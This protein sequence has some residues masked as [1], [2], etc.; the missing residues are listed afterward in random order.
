LAHLKRTRKASTPFSIVLIDAAM[1]EMDGFSLAERINA[2]SERAENMLLMLPFPDRQGVTHP[3]SGDDNKV[4]GGPTIVCVRK[5]V[6]QMELKAAIL[7]LLGQNPKAIP[8]AG[9]S[10]PLA[11]RFVNR[12]LRILMAEDNPFNQRVTLLMLTK[13]GHS[14]AVVVNGREAIAALESASF[15]LVLMDL[16][17]PEMDGFEATAAIRLA[18]AG[19]SRHVPIIALTAHAMKED[20]DRCLK[21]G[22][23]GYVSKPIQ[24]DKLRQAIED[25]IFQIREADDAEPLEGVTESPMDVAAALARIDGDR[26]FL[27]EMAAMFRDQ[28]PRFLEE[29]RAGI[30]SADMAQSAKAV[31]A[32]KNWLANFVALPAL[33][34]AQVLEATLQAGNL[35]AASELLA[36][37]RHQFEQFAPELNRLA[38][39]PESPITSS[40]LDKNCRQRPE[41]YICR[42]QS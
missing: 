16:Q 30:D 20:R 29:A 5:P 36:T 10:D 4:C 9:P 39:G 27:A 15:D 25:C 35:G 31:H 19:T 22:M 24:Q 7:K 12:S 3:I 41:T 6:Q 26:A 32:L 13:L 33:A 28:A 42:A 37:L 1:P 21:A 38:S 17:M 14:V 18:E 40:C 11:Q 23:D 8:Q 34:T 2:D